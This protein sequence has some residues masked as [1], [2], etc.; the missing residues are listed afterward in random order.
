[1][2]YVIN[3]YDYR[4]AGTPGSPASNGRQGVPGAEGKRGKPGAPGFKGAQ[5]NPGKVLYASFLQIASI[6]DPLVFNPPDLYTI[7]GTERRAP[8]PT[9]SN[10]FTWST[11]STGS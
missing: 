6:I 4:E 11:W 1:M 7:S 10:G 3:I 8:R 5:G 9:G 2:H